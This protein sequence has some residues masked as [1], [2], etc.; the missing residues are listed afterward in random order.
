MGASLLLPRGP[1]LLVLEA[2]HEVASLLLPR[3]PSFLVLKAVHGLARSA[4]LTTQPLK[5]GSSLMGGLR[6]GGLA[7]AGAH[8]RS[9]PRPRKITREKHPGGSGVLA[10]RQVEE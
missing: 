5:V 1:S 10:G 7:H 9:H 6:D 3:A 2:V 8:P 4:G